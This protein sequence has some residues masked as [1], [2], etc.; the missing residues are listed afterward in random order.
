MSQSSSFITSS[1][2]LAQRYFPYGIS[3]SGEF[4]SAQAKLLEQHGCAYQA[5]HEGKREPVCE[6]E[7]A[8]IAV[9]RGER[10]PETAHEKV[11]QLYLQKV[12][13]ITKV[14]SSSGVRSRPLESLSDGESYVD[15]DWEE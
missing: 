12:A 14:P 10:Q 6:E 4:T 1:K 13:E 8:F 3:R 2:F 15:T 11:W 7:Q 5:L 9:C